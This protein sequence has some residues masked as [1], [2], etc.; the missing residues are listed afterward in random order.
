MPLL[1]D[2]TPTFG[3]LEDGDASVGTSSARLRADRDRLRQELDDLRAY[4]SAP[5]QTV[6]DHPNA[7]LMTA[8]HNLSGVVATEG[9]SAAAAVPVDGWAGSERPFYVGDVVKVASSFLPAGTKRNQLRV[10]AVLEG[11]RSADVR[12]PDDTTLYMVPCEVLE[13]GC[14]DSNV[15]AEIRKWFR[16]CM[17]EVTRK[18]LPEPPVLAPSRSPSEW[19]PAGTDQPEPRRSAWLQAGSATAR[20]F[21]YK[22]ETGGVGEAQAAALLDPNS[23][24]CGLRRAGPEIFTSILSAGY[25]TLVSW[26]NEQFPLNV[27]DQNHTY[28]HF[29]N[30][31]KAIDMALFP[32]SPQEKLHYLAEHDS[33]ELS[34]RHL[35]SWIP[36][37]RTGDKD[38]AQAM[39]ALQPSGSRMDIAPSWLVAESG[40]VSQNE[41][42][43]RERARG[44]KNYK[45]DQGGGGKGV[46]EG[47][48]KGKAKRGSPSGPKGDKKEE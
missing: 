7:E 17:V 10:L 25:P 15:G 42:K 3:H 38:A 30:D 48:E 33:C 41:H 31:L 16:D 24:P 43:R 9:P 1:R 2:P 44:Q 18:E 4:P 32:L 27:R 6:A 39:L 47:K 28:L 14:L 36:E 13:M 20:P 11:P 8:L 22:P 19:L 21:A 34:L 37:R 40:L 35:A 45:D 12:F 46:G 5:M 23:R 29:F 26:L